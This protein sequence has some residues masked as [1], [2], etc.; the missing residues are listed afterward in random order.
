MADVADNRDIGLDHLVDRRGV[1]I[2]VRLGRFRAEGVD[3]P[4]EPV[5]EPRADIDQEIAIMHRHIGLIE[6]VH[7]KHAQPVLTRSRITAEPHQ[8]RGDRK[9]RGLDQLA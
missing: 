9:A 8:R 5:I 2:N 7:A 3:A 6:A 4:G 1:N